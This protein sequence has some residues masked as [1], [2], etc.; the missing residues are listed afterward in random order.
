MLFAS[1]PRRIADFVTACW[2]PSSY[3]QGPYNLKI[4]N[5]ALHWGKKFLP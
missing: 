1:V 3:F 4:E 2:F 5:R